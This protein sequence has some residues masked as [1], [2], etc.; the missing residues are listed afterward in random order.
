MKRSEKTSRTWIKNLSE[1]RSG[2]AMIKISLRA[3]KQGN[4]MQGISGR[5]SARQKWRTGK[6][7]GTVELYLQGRGLI[8][9]ALVKLKT[10]DLF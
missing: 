6:R 4:K 3:G 8:P 7:R 9:R 5:R 10:Y 1:F 2:E